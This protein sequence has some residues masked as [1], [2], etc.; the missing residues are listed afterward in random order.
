MHKEELVEQYFSGQISQE[1]FL[2]LKALLQEDVA[3]KEEFYSQLEVQETIAQE[4]Q[5]LL[6]ARLKK[7]DQKPVEKINWYRYAAAA[8][9]LIIIGLLFY[10][11]KPNYEKLYETKIGRESCRE[12]VCQYV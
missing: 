10:R 5:A 11:P 3:F 7:L 8:A 6:K 2:Q 12:R 9:A 1:A 4:K